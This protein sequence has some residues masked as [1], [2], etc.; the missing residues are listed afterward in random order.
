LPSEANQTPD[1]KNTMTIKIQ[2]RDSK[3]NIIAYYNSV[4]PDE[5][6]MLN[7][8]AI[9]KAFEKKYGK[10]AYMISVHFIYK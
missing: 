8:S 6:M 2:C 4:P 1:S 10:F 9:K 3:G 5:N 7:I